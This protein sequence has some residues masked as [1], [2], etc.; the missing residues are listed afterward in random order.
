MLRRAAVS[1]LVLCAGAGPVTAQNR[2]HQQ[3]AAEIQMLQQQNQQLSLAL[4]QLTE[5]LKSVNTRLD[6]NE[7]FQQR[8]FA[9]QELLVKNLGSDLSAIR[10]R[11]QDTDTRLRTLRDEIDALRQTFLALPALLAQAQAAS[12]PLDPDN[13]NAAAPAPDGAAPPTIPAPPPILTLPSTAGLSPN[14]L[15]DTAFADYGSSQY[16]LAISG[17]EQVVST[18]PTA[19]RA[20]DAQFFIGESLER[21]NRLPEAIAAYNLVIQN[22]PAGDQIDMAYYK[23]GFVEAQMGR[24]DAARATFEEVV[25][26]YPDSPGALLARQRL[27]ARDAALCCSI[28]ALLVFLS[29]RSKRICSLVSSLERFSIPS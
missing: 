17:F 16:A 18:F 11:T 25:K 1:L 8:R 4:T 3:L 14:R 22:Y 9:D 26:R 24:T 12:A 21:L 19:E 23:R 13:P 27:A 28:K 5:V 15:F 20:D 10:E 2:E 29:A 7:Q 6:A